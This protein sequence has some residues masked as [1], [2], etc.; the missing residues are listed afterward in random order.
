MKQE[1]ID[2]RL[3]ELETALFSEIRALEDQISALENTNEDHGFRID[4]LEGDTDLEDR[5]R[6]LEA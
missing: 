2:A 6:E 5:V 3:N 1:Y 4:H